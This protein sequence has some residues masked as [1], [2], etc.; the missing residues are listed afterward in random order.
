M[1]PSVNASPNP[2]ADKF[3]SMMRKKIP[4]ETQQS[5][6][7]LLVQNQG[8]DTMNQ[9]QQN[10]PLQQEFVDIPEMDDSDISNNQNVN[11]MVAAA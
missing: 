1:A 5:N 2:L 9:V 6:K 11:G 8:D 7:Q 4:V 3:G 10:Q